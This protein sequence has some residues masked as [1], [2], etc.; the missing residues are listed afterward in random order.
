MVQTKFAVY[1]SLLLALKRAKINEAGAT[2]T[3]LLECFIESGGELKASAVETRELC[4]IGKFKVWR[5]ELIAK[6][7]L[8]YSIGSYSHHSP[9][10]KLL[11]YINKEKSTTFELATTDE[12]RA[13]DKKHDKTKADLEARLS[14][15]EKAISELIELIDPPGSEEKIQGF[16][17]GTYHPKLV[18]LN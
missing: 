17:N 16:L 15:A 6:G 14:K 12:L 5:D 1:Q 11:K 2:A 4:P 13:V 3:L 10:P 18:S 8:T 9:G 7:W